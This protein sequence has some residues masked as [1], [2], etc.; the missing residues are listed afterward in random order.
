MVEV[1]GR[2]T[3]KSLTYD[4]VLKEGDGTQMIVE[5]IVFDEQLPD[6]LFSK[7]SLRK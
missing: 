5:S 1:E 4:D 2:W 3:A 7:A 6:H